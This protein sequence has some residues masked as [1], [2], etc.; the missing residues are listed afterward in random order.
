MELTFVFLWA[1]QDPLHCLTQGF[2]TSLLWLV[3]SLSNCVACGLYPFIMWAE[4]SR[5]N[6]KIPESFV[7]VNWFGGACFTFSMH[8]KLHITLHI[9]LPTFS[10]SL[11]CLFP[12]PHLTFCHTVCFLTGCSSTLLSY[13]SLLAIP[14]SL[15]PP[16]SSP[17]PVWFCAPLPFITCNP[18]LLNKVCVPLRGENEP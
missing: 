16:L 6:C 18:C 13:S 3:V 10:A 8:I 1:V 11:L 15:P 4:K 9:K 14:S 7:C 5:K 2:I 12:S 17:Q